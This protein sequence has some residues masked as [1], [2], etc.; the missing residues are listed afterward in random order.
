MASTRHLRVRDL[1]SK[2]LLIFDGN[3]HFC[4]RWV[5]RWRELT[6]GAVE[7]AP[8]QEV[9]ARFPEIP[10]DAFENAVHFIERDGTV[11][12]GA[13]AVFRSLGTLR[14]G[15]W[16]VWCY[17]HFPGF[18][19]IM[20]LAYAFIARNRQLASFFT[21]LFWGHDVRQPT[22]LE[23]RRWFLRSFGAI[24]LIAFISLSLQVKGLIGEQGIS[25]VREYL[26][27]AR[28]HLGANAPFLLPTLC[29]INSG[30]AFLHFLCGAGAVVS[31]LLMAGMAPVVSL[32]LLFALYLSLTIAGQ[33]FLSFQ[34]DILLL[35]A[36][37]LAIFF[38]PLRWRMIANREA[39]FSRAGF[40][41]LKLLLFKLMLMSGVVK[42]TSGDGSW[43]NLSALD[44]HYWSQPLP[45]VIGWW[46]DQHPEWFKK[47]SVAFCLFV[48]IIVPLFIWAPRR[49]RHI[50]ASLLIFLQVAI[51]ATG[52][53]CFFNL[54]TIA[55]C[56]LL[57]DDAL[58]RPKERR[59][60][61]RRIDDS[62]RFG[63][64]PSQYQHWPAIAVLLIT[65]PLN[66]AHI[67][68]AFRTQ[69]V[70][71]RPIAALH[72]FVEP[73]RIVNGYGLFRVMTKS[74]PEI[75]VEGSADGLEWL[76]YEF[77]WKPGGLDKA[78]QWAAPHQPRLDWQMWFAALGN[79]R[80]NPW[81]V[82]LLE[83]LLRNQ[84]EVTRLL[85]RN[86]FPNE[87]PRYVRARLYEYRFADTSEHRSTG[88]WWKREERGEY[89]PTVS[90]ENFERR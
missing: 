17:E 30:D 11:Y 84:P 2:A 74:R 32:V 15:R 73:F 67:F 55:L 6:A 77:R 4:R 16:L 37:F 23:S 86:P 41:L 36:G 31:V 8:S 53:Y 12:R 66:A 51:A 87:P 72:G 21:R 63:K 28:E 64:R 78:P 89:L 48:E 60:L 82:S 83:R 57:I 20:E 49:L 90:L 69:A 59:S 54:L 68:S 76:P 61:D 47:F 56:L 52:N 34:W 44:Y 9:A 88:A 7:Y 24:Y 50:A 33:T 71:P 39:P 5:E 18:A 10:R 62:G 75:I 70:W 43:W 26:H 14:S 22:Y 19:A 65:L 46:A 29:W 80:R 42:L 45:T 25:P 79:Y 13:E 85:A 1:P 35:E 40:F 58:W 81:F 27:L 3:C 38:A